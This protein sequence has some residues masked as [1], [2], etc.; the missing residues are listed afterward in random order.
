MTKTIFKNVVLVAIFASFFSFLGCT[1][2]RGELGS[3]SN[4]VKFYLIP[5][6]DAKILENTAAKMVEYLSEKTGYKFKVAIPA[7]YV[8]VV[9]AFGSSHADMSALNTYGYVMAHERF[10]VEARLTFV[11]GGDEVYKSA[12]V[13]R[14]DSN[15]NSV[16]DLEGKKFAYVDPSSA[17]GFILPAK[18][19]RDNG[20]KLGKTTFAYKHDSALMMVYQ[21]QMDGGACF[22][23]PPN[24]EGPQD[25]RRLLLKQFPDAVEKLKILTLT[26]AIPNDPIVFRKDMPKEMKDKITDAL[27][28]Y[29]ETPEGKVNLKEMYAITGMVRSTDARY[30]GVRKMFADIKAEGS[31]SP[32]ATK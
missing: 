5:S 8:A 11:R 17:S 19:F 22:Y 7:S 15:I 14:A 1:R 26:E 16:K 20:V 29:M 23:S 27:L 3:A 24:E 28:A 9:E 21:K 13:V 32:A 10:G 30:D 6:V 18:M 2:D 25:A 12:I 4:P 31:A